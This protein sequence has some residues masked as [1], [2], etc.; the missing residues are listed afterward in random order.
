MVSLRGLGTRIFSN[1][2][3]IEGIVDNVRCSESD[4]FEDGAIV[5]GQKTVESEIST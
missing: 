5:A 2:P 1:G 3:E 4:E